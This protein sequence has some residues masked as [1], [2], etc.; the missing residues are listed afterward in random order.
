MN[1]AI[2]VFQVSMKKFMR[3]RSRGAVGVL[4][5]AGRRWDGRMSARNWQTMPDS[6][7]ISL[8]RMP[9][10]IFREGTRPRW[11]C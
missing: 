10:E 8:C 3:A 7:I 11:G 2:L 1:E 5:E 4:I 9:F 6:V